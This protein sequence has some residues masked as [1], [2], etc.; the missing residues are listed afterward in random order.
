MLDAL[1][2][3]HASDLSAVPDAPPEP[4]AYR[5]ESGRPLGPSGR[6]HSYFEH[7]DRYRHGR[8]RSLKCGEVLRTSHAAALGAEAT[9]RL[10]ALPTY[11]VERTADT[12]EAAA[13]A[14]E[15][16]FGVGQYAGAGECEQDARDIVGR[17]QW[18]RNYGFGLWGETW[19][20]AD[21]L[22]WPRRFDTIYAD[23]IVGWVAER[24]MDG[25]S[26]SDRV[27]AA[28]QRVPSKGG[29]T[30]IPL[31]QVLYAVRMP[32]EGGAEGVPLLRHVFPQFDAWLD[33]VRAQNV[34][35]QR[36]ALPSPV[37]TWLDDIAE[38]YGF[39]V[40]PAASQDEQEAARAR[41]QAEMD[42]MDAMLA[43]YASHHRARLIMPPW[44]SR[45]EFFG[46]AEQV[47]PA[48]LEPV[49]SAKER[50]I[51][52]VYLH[53]W[54]T[55]GRAGSGGSYNLV[56]TQRDAAEAAAVADVRWALKAINGQSVARFM[57]WNFS[58]LPRRAWPRLGAK[59]PQRSAFLKH[60]DAVL[61]L[62]QAGYLTPTAADEP[63]FRAGLEMADT[64]DEAAG[65]TA[66]DR[67]RGAAVS[68]A[69]AAREVT[70]TSARDL[71]RSGRASNTPTEDA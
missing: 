42:R 20:A 66:T 5:W 56:E 10:T 33:A 23:S 4:S 62:T 71:V 55:S 24:D 69:R 63:E 65:R 67:S 59:F 49:I 18:A 41:I 61:G 19:E 14:L 36:F 8:A 3:S 50:A 45:P 46:G 48:R 47:D 30:V 27:V 60:V 2:P 13:D 1:T 57:R 64:P 58:A 25:G 53:G 28:R 43:E 32:D 26:K 70:R 54:I 21:G 34:A 51:L 31:D 35:V 29:E 15:R 12:D 39:A 37:I 22:Y 52:E 40:D 68:T 16:A 9:R 38:R 7:A 11:Y 6:R 17:M 44:F